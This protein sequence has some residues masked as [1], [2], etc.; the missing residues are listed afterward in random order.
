MA[1][2]AEDFIRFLK[3]NFP[4]D[5][6]RA[7]GD[8]VPDDI[9]TAIVSRHKWHYEI[10]KNVPEWI[11]SQNGDRVPSEVLNGNKT[12]KDYVAEEEKKKKEKEQAIEAGTSVLIVGY[13]MESAAVLSANARFRALLVDALQNGKLTPAQFQQWL[14]TRQSDAEIIAKD[15]KENQPEK[16]L[17]HALKE[18]SRDYQRVMKNGTES[19]KL[20]A[21]ANIGYELSAKLAPLAEFMKT[22][23]G[24]AQF[25]EYLRQTPQQA[26]LR[27]MANSTPEV[28]NRFMSV[29][30]DNGLK[31]EPANRSLVGA[32]REELFDRLKKDY[33]TMQ[34]RLVPLVT[35]EEPVIQNI[36]LKDLNADEK[37]YRI[38][39][40]ALV[41]KMHR[42]LQKHY[43]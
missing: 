37:G 24:R 20:G 1:N 11:K 29:M 33:N 38:A 13:A 6:R 2:V 14:A 15:W 22:K 30:R 9:L 21:Q 18:I 17:F 39:E 5:Y 23:E 7:S 25:A 31:I 40:M 41:S 32:T 34:A 27:Q 36:R 42:G 35:R 4:D 28:L 12:V 16:Y 10:W 19:E 26:A 8:S 43:A 3:A